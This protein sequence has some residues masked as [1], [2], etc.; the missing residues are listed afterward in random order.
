VESNREKLAAVQQLVKNYWAKF[1]DE[2]LKF[3]SGKRSRLVEKLQERYD[4]SP[5][6]AEMDIRI[7]DARLGR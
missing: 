5:H 7:S 4:F 2:D 1:T 3:I 6:E